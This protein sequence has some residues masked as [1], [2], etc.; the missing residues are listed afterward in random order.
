MGLVS[1]QKNLGDFETHE[2]K[3]ALSE[4]GWQRRCDTLVVISTALMINP[5][6]RT[7]S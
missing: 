2:G 3:L 5:Q 1:S 6:C 7:G 4:V